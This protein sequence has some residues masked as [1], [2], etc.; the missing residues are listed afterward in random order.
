MNISSE[1][2]EN[3]AI[4]HIDGRLDTVTAPDLDKYILSIPGDI[5]SVILDLEKLEYISSAGLRS[6]LVIYKRMHFFK[7]T[8]KVIN[9]NERIKFAFE[10]SGLLEM[11]TK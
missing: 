10:I 5:K 9:I 3:E 8:F 11:L 1:F 2:N 6:I 4:L 7:G